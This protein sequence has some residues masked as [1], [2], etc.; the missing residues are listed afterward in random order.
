MYLGEKVEDFYNFV[1]ETILNKYSKENVFWTVLLSQMHENWFS[2]LLRKKHYLDDNKEAFDG[3]YGEF[4]ES[5]RQNPDRITNIHYM[6]KA[7]NWCSSGS[8]FKT[9]T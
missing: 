8:G 4:L 9:E 7:V 2:F 6:L 5:L 1:R 3:A